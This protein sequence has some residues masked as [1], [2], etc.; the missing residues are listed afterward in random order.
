[1]TILQERFKKILQ[2]DDKLQEVILHKSQILKA[3]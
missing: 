1:M 2:R 3:N